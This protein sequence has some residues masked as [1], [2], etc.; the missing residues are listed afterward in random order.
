MVT[1]T[2]KSNVTSKWWTVCYHAHVTRDWILFDFFN[3]KDPLNELTKNSTDQEMHVRVRAIAC[4]CALTT[5]QVTQGH[6]ALLTVQL[7]LLTK[8]TRAYMIINSFELPTVKV[9]SITW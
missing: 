2:V 7:G 6:V 8:L 3:F 4:S 5:T 1:S 9:S